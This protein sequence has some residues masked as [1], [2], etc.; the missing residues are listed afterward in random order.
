[1]KVADF[2]CDVLSKLWNHPESDFV[3]GPGLDVTLRTM[4]QGDVTVQ[5]FAVYLSERF[6]R[7]S[8]ERILAQLEIF[9][10]KLVEPGHIAWLKWR[11]QAAELRL[12]NRRWGVLSL[13]GVDGL[14][15]NLFYVRLCYEMGVRLM[16]LTWNHANWAA[17]GVMEKRGSGL[18][19][20][21]RELV[22]LMNE[23]GIVPDVSHLSPDGFWELAELTTGPFIA[24]HSNAYEVCRHPRNLS[25]EQIR[26]LIAVGGLIGV[27]FVPWFVRSDAAV[28]KAEDLLPHVERICEL[29]GAKH[30]VFGSDFDG[31]DQWIEGLE[32]P[33][34]YPDWAALLLKY[35]PEQLV[36]DWMNGNAITFLEKNLPQRPL[37]N[38]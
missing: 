32:S 27:T 8:M 14:E 31:I 29:G 26:A 6:G 17:D 38:T 11:E 35:Y 22:K 19:G 30:L 10:R 3:D 18:T 21:G 13:E 34:R 7:P 33:A 15:G 4:E 24:S 16:G 2:H 25:D 1:M 20:K 37:S 12:N 5:V 23:L 9:R 36:R 28:V